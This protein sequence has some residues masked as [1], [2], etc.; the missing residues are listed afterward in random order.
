MS[1]IRLRTTTKGLEVRVDDETLQSDE[2]I[3]VSVRPGHQAAPTWLNLT[4]DEAE[5]LRNGLQWAILDAKA[6]KEGER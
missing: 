4:I 2:P 1:A 3:E 5:E 6:W